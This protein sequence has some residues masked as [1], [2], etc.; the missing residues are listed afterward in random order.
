MSATNLSLVFQQAEKNIPKLQKMVPRLQELE[1]NLRNKLRSLILSVCSTNQTRSKECN[2]AAEVET[3]WL[4]KLFDAPALRLNTFTSCFC[5]V[6]HLA[7]SLWKASC[8]NPLPC[9]LLGHHL[10]LLSVLRP[11]AVLQ[12]YHRGSLKP[13]LSLTS[14]EGS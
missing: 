6:Q 11:G 14:K 12:N 3:T 2:T 9:R 7:G 8:P 1:D 13:I 10:W 5:P 4:A